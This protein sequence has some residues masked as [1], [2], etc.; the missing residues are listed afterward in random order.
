VI[1]LSATTGLFGAI[2]T[3]GG[4][5]DQVLRS[6]GLSRR[7]VSNPH[8]FVAYPSLLADRGTLRTLRKKFEAAFKDLQDECLTCHHSLTVA[9]VVVKKRWWQMQTL[10]PSQLSVQIDL[11]FDYS[12]RGGVITP[13]EAGG[14]MSET[15]PLVER[16]A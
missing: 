1:S 3:G 7:D 13:L 15:F 8:G 12:A 9:V 16:Q 5:P 10:S 6:C 4:D 2:T 11:T 14:W